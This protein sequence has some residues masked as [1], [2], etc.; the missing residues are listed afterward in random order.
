MVSSSST[1][2]LGWLGCFPETGVTYGAAGS[3]V[4]HVQPKKDVK[5]S[6]KIDSI[7]MRLHHK[8]NM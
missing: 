7:V 4:V 6:N 5:N 1:S 8:F 2:V 3:A